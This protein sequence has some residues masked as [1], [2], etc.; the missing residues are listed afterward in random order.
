MCDNTLTYQF[1]HMMSAAKKE[2]CNLQ[3]SVEADG[4][5]AKLSS[6]GR[7]GIKDQGSYSLDTAPLLDFAHYCLGLSK[8][9]LGGFALV[10]HHLHH[11]NHQANIPISSPST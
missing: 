4:G 11:F 9:S 5:P 1:C 6:I 7:G 2:Q 8:P 3:H 10:I